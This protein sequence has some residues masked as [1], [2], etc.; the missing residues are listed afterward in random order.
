MPFVFAS[1]TY[2]GNV[3]N[4]NVG[5]GMPCPY[6]VFCAETWVLK[7][8]QRRSIRLPDY[9]YTADGAYFFT[10][11]TCEKACVFG[12]IIESVMI[13]NEWGQIVQAEW[14]K[15]AALRPYIELDAFVVMPNHFHGILV[16]KDTVDQGMMHHAPTKNSP[17]SRQFS[18]P[19]ADSVASIM[20]TF[21]A[22]VTRQINRLRGEISPPIWQRN[23]Y[24]HIIRDPQRYE[25]IRSY[26]ETNPQ[27]WVEDSLYP[28]P[29]PE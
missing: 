15:T 17:S 7:M 18:K 26:I 4:D 9:D 12:E 14:E 10:I 22:A 29:K 13:L 16:I 6:R 3:L 24:E 1:C 25:F 2:I 8:P 19:Q 11:C 20:G 28:K 23:Y 5:H 27:R 21:K